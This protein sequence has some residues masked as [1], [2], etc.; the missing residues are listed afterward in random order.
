MAFI[1]IIAGLSAAFFWG[2]SDYLVSKP[3][4]VLG[5][6]NAIA[7]SMLFSMLTILPFLLITGTGTGINWFVIFL[8]VLSA[9]GFFIGQLFL[10][11]AF[12]YGNLSIIAP[13]A[14]SY[15]LITVVVAVFA[16]GD[17]LN[18]IQEV[19]I[20]A[21]LVGMILTSTKFSKLKKGRTVLAAGVGS[22]IVSMV[23]FAAPGIYSGPYAAI[24][25]FALLSMIWRVV[26]SAGGFITGRMA[27]QDMAPPGKPY[28]AYVA[29]AGITDAFAT[30]S[31]AYGI[32]VQSAA[33]PIVSALSGM[34]TLFLIVFAVIL[35]KER[36]ESNQWAG[37]VL[38]IA[39][40]I[41]LS[42]FM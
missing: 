24:L 1:P 8:A 17:V 30:L 37:M 32:Q 28:I 42:Y 25:G 41:T 6:Y 38:A 10:Y 9:I 14:Y 27:K 18:L 12:K 3:V 22:A 23:M 39:G 21:I 36:P 19:S 7:Y 5:H 29:G 16:F 35:L 26:A 33:L 13:I 11:R 4:R 2:L 20:A 34:A 40:V 31:F 15:P